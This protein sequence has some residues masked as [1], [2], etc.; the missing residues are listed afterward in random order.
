MIAKLSYV[1]CDDCGSPSATVP[2]L[3]ILAGSWLSTDGRD[4]CP[5]CRESRSAKYRRMDDEYRAA[6]NRRSH[7]GPQ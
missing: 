4:L 5:G 7:T 3:L 6:L 2:E 1:M